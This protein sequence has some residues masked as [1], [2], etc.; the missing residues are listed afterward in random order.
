MA[1]NSQA[2]KTATTIA[3]PTRIELRGI[4]CLTVELSGARAGV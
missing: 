3:R 2:E 1:L 4:G